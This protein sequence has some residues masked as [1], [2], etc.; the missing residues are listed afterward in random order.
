[1]TRYPACGKIESDMRNDT[2]HAFNT[3]TGK[4]GDVP[5]RIFEH[6][7][8]SGGNLIEVRQGMKS[9]ASELYRPRTTDEFLREK[10]DKVAGSFLNTLPDN[11]NLEEAE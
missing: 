6:P 4:V 1:M 5:R 10:P 11:D 7:I 9:Y 3:K 2:V 8:L